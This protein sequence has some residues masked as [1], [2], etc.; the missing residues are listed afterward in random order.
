MARCL[1]EQEAYSIG[2][3]G[4]PVTNRLCTWARAQELGCIAKA[5]YSYASNQIVYEGSLES[6]GAQYGNCICD[7]ESY[8][9]GAGQGQWR[10]VREHYPYP[11]CSGCGC[12]PGSSCYRY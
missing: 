3:M 10:C 4:S 5:G 11:A 8:S 1:T 6:S 12:T 9:G 7:C 2:G